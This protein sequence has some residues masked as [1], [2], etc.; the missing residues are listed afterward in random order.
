MPV[1]SNGSGAYRLDFSEAVGAVLEKLQRRSRRRGQA[2]EFAAAFRKIVRRLRHNPRNVGEPLYRLS[3]L[4]LEVR[5]L[6]CPPLVV[7][8]AVSD[9]HRIVYIKGARLLSRHDP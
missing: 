5:T 9:E 3:K 7:D 2:K 8:F 1:S 4:R 6:A